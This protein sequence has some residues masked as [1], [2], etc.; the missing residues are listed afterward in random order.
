MLKITEQEKLILRNNAKSEVKRLEHIFEDR[1]TSQLL[2]SFKNKYNVC[3]TA[4]KIILK[5][6][7]EYKGYINNEYLKVT[8]TQVPH[9]LCFAGYNFDKEL[10]T[11]LFGAKSQSGTTVKKL[12]DAVTHGISAKAIDEISTRKDELFGYM[13]SFLNIIKSYDNEE[14]A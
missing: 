2:D 8:M 3:E 4:Y 14:A 1:T 10:L 9:A 13:D 6:H 12:R 11:N 5:K 7:Q